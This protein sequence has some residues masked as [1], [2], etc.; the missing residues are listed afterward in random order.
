MTSEKF[1]DPSDYASHLEAEALQEA[2]SK[3]KAERPPGD[4]DG[5]TCT[6][7]YTLIPEGRLATGAFRCIECQ[8]KVENDRRLHGR[9]AGY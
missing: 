9:H 1:A 2:L 6:V 4:F 3:R 8:T 7:C 5:E